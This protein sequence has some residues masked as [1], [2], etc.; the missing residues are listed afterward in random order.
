MV[1]ALERASRISVAGMSNYG[2]MSTGNGVGQV[3]VGDIVVNVE[4]LDTDDDYEELA[5]KVSNI[6]VERIGRT[7]VV[8]GMRIAEP[9]A[10]LAIAAA[11]VSS[12][13]NQPIRADA[14]LIGEVGLSGELRGANKIPARLKE[15]AK[16]GFTMAVIPRVSQKT[17]ESLP[18][19][20][21]VVE[22]RSLREA[23]KAVLLKS[24][25]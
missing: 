10:D 18:K 12:A 23:L 16:L 24:E 4:N 9:A 6:L 8:G 2:D 20:M 5:E 7:A 14:V 13:K 22:A 11:I 1:A 21:Q 19:D 3:S 25:E 15:A 17:R